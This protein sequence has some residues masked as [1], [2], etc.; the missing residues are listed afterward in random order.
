MKQ[1]KGENNYPQAL[2]EESRYAK[3][4][5]KKFLDDK[6]KISLDESDKCDESDDSLMKKLNYFLIDNKISKKIIVFQS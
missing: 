1:E 6:S 4:L 5:I 3:K 2:L